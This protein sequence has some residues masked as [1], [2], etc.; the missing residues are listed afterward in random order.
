MN[1]ID[2]GLAMFTARPDIYDMA[3][4]PYCLVVTLYRPHFPDNDES[5]NIFEGHDTI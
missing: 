3:N 2:D 5:W 4:K 1:T